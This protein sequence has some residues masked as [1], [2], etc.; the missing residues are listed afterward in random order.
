[1]LAVVAG[2]EPVA[3]PCRRRRRDGPVTGADAV[4]IR[5]SA[6]MLFSLGLTGAVALRRQ[7][8]TSRVA[9]SWRCFLVLLAS[10]AV[11][12]WVGIDTIVNRIYRWRLERIQQPARCVG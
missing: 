1:M 7:P 12:A 10:V 4:A 11:T 9:P 6:A 2:R 3:P 5:D 8:R